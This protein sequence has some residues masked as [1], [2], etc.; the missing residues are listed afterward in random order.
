MLGIALKFWWQ[1]HLWEFK[2]LPFELSIYQDHE[3]GDTCS[4]KA[5]GQVDFVSRQNVGQLMQLFYSIS[6][7]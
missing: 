3:A 6:G 7:T 4:K 1:G 2:V 5:R